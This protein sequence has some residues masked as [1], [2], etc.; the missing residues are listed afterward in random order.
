MWARIFD[1]DLNMKVVTKLTLSLL[2]SLALL[3]M[4]SLAGHHE[5]GEH[6]VAAEQM[7]ADAVWASGAKSG[8]G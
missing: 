3:P 5:G 4:H 2:A 6:A 1:K 8:S 7:G